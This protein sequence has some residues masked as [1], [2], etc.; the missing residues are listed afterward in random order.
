MN[1]RVGALLSYFTFVILGVL[2]STTDR[3]LIRGKRLVIVL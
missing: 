1:N 2:E 3:F